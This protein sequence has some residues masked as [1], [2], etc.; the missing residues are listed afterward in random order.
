MEVRGLSSCVPTQI[1]E[2]ITL[3]GHSSHCT[4][5]SSLRDVAHTVYERSSQC[6]SVL[7][8]ISPT[9]CED[10]FLA[11]LESNVQLAATS[12][13]KVARTTTEKLV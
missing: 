12:T 7:S 11:L 13:K 8:E 9:L 10:S 6:A 4:P 3:R 2:D 1:L 5:N